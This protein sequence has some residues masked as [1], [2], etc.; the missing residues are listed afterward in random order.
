MVP[1]DR[2]GERTRAG[3]C[4]TGQARP[5]HRE[6]PGRPRAP[7]ATAERGGP[8]GDGRRPPGAPQTTPR[9]G[10]RGPGSP[11]PRGR[12][13]GAVAAALAPAR[14]GE[15]DDADP[16]ARDSSRLA[17]A[18][19][20]RGGAGR[21][22]AGVPGAGPSDPTGTHRHAR[23]SAH[24]LRGP[25]GPPHPHRRRHGAHHLGDPPDARRVPG[26]QRG[27]RARDPGGRRRDP[28]RAGRT[29]RAPRRLGQRHGHAPRR[30]GR[31]DHVGLRGQD[32]RSPRSPSA[33]ATPT[34]RI[35]AGRIRA[36]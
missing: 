31:G 25:E 11:C 7:T 24:G 14:R 12:G 35:R 33:S 4:P 20:R 8:Q 19:H 10:P 17:L 29:R 28:D 21:A 18:L 2:P 30:L 9:R 22:G 6:A 1:R 34:S 16:C 15:P 13:G 32:E 26:R 36:P 23:R 27:G 5:G 3:A